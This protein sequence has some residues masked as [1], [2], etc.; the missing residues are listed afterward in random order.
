MGA[1]QKDTR[2]TQVRVAEVVGKGKDGL[3]N[4]KEW[5]NREY[6][7]PVFDN[8]EKPPPQSPF[9]DFS[10]PRRKDREKSKEEETEGAGAKT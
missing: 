6:T 5:K 9:I 3:M 7:K 1:D 4:T 2:K 10:K 8:S